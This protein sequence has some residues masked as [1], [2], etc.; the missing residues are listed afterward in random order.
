[1]LIGTHIN[2]A[3]TMGMM[4]DKPVSTAQNPGWLKSTHKKYTHANP[5]CI[6]AINGTPTALLTVCAC[7]SLANNIIF[8]RLN[9]K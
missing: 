2:P 1:M 8:S 5:P 9:G 4:E 7:N 3:P 6:I